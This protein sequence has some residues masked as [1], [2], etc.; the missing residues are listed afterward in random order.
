MKKIQNYKKNTKIKSNCLVVPGATYSEIIKL[1]DFSIKCALQDKNLKLTFRLHPMVR[2]DKILKIMNLKIKLLPRNIKIS[3]KSL[4]ED[5]KNNSF[6]LYTDSAAVIEAT[7]G[8]NI[9]IYLNLNN[10]INNDP[11]YDYP[12]SKF[13]VNT[14]SDFRKILSNLKSIKLRK[15]KMNAEKIFHKI[16]GSPN[17]STI[18]KSLNLKNGN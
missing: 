17:L 5:I 14:L 1:F 10:K 15:I 7:R 9:P 13:Y 11:I 2:I 6:V 18:Y 12:E 16:Y 4:P 3:T 8:G